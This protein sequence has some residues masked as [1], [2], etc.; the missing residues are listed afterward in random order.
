MYTGQH[1][2]AVNNYTQLN[3]LANAGYT[4][5]QV[6]DLFPTLVKVAPSGFLKTKPEFRT[7]YIVAEAI[8]ALIS[9][10]S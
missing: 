3:R 7:V 6:R 9:A 8:D 1:E 2:N 4:P 10:R 5:A